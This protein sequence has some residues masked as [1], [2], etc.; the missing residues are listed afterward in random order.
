MDTD[1]NDAAVPQLLP[2]FHPMKES[3][4][5]KS[6]SKM[7]EP[8]SLYYGE[9]EGVMPL[10]PDGHIAPR[11]NSSTAAGSDSVSVPIGVHIRLSGVG[12]LSS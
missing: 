3:R 1:E 2:L 7:R 12:F 11:M 8:S 10:S 5:P 4:V 6:W 9:F